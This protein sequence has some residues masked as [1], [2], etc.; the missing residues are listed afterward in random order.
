MNVKFFWPAS[1]VKTN[2]IYFDK[3]YE[4]SVLIMILQYV[5][6]F[7]DFPNS[8]AFDTLN[9]ITLLIVNLL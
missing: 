2:T 6:S 5:I 4:R 7:E 8:S 9:L 3:S 1:Y